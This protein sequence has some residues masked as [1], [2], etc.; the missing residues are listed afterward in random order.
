MRK[1]ASFCR[2]QANRS[3]ETPFL[4]LPYHFVCILHRKKEVIDVNPNDH[5][6]AWLHSLGRKPDARSMDKPYS[7]FIGISLMDVPFLYAIS[8]FQDVCKTKLYPFLRNEYVIIVQSKN[9]REVSIFICCSDFLS[10]TW[11]FLLASTVIVQ[12]QRYGSGLWK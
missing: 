8:I 11:S 9:F 10:S 5:F 4:D 12:V 3:K 1:S 6:H 2:L 7:S